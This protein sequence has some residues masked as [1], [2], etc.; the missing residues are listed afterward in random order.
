MPNHKELLQ[1]LIK[2]DASLSR[3]YN[4]MSKELALVL[5]KYKVNSNSKIWHRNM[6]VQKEVDVILKRYQKIILNYISNNV[7][8]AWNLSDVHNDHFVSNYIKGISITDAQ[9]NPYYQ[10]NLVALESFKYR[11][12]DGLKLSDRVWN[13]TKQTQNQLEYFV[14]EGL[15][16]GRSAVQLAGDIKR[17]LKEPEKRF[18]RIRDKETGKLK[19]SDPSKDYRPGR[20]V[21]RSSYKNALRLTRNEINIAYRTADYERRKKLPFVLGIEVHLSPAHPQY[22]ICDELQGKYPKGFKFTGWH[23]NCLCFS[24]AVLMTKQQFKQYLK[25]G[26]I[27]S[28]GYV[29]E[30]P[31]RASEY[32]ESKAPKIKKLKTYPYFIQDNFK[33]TKKGFSLKKKVVSVV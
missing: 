23:P 31:K 32:L 7:S 15:T 20:G 1:F 26:R 25:T 29:K 14:S 17:Y 30:L 10:R 22:D 11:V 2:Q 18:R 24:T 28:G 19:L 27:D 9:K 3:I 5:K 16:E 12:A 21:Y 6:Q 4:S 13:L 8:D 33:N